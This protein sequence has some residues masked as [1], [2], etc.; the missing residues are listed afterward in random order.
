MVLFDNTYSILDALELF[1]L[2]REARYVNVNEIRF[3]IN[4]RR[5]P[6]LYDITQLRKY[7][8]TRIQVYIGN[9]ERANGEMRKLR[10]EA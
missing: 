5:C 2:P 6:I 1:H 4:R 8:L 3:I 10:S 9:D 7:R